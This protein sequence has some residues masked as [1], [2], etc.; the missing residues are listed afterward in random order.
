MRVSRSKK[1]VSALSGVGRK[2]TTLIKRYRKD[3]HY[4]AD[5]YRAD[6]RDLEAETKQRS[7]YQDNPHAFDNHFK[8][9]R[10]RSEAAIHDEK[11]KQPQLHPA[12]SELE[13]T[14]NS[15]PPTPVDRCDVE[16]R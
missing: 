4:T 11:W 13:G 2:A 14:L 10:D 3:Y 8:D 16:V 12:A 7:V 5:E 6:I 1:T 9:I 15:L